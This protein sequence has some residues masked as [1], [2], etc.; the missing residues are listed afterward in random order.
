[1]AFYHGTIRDL[2]RQMYIAP[3]HTPHSETGDPDG[4]VFF[5]D[6]YELAE[7]W[8]WLMD[9]EGRGYE[10]PIHVYEVY[11]VGE[12]EPDRGVRTGQVAPGNYQSRSPLRIIREVT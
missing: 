12:I 1:M 8:P 2:S 10:G 3:G 4:L 11:P 6:E 5:T 7:Q 9:V